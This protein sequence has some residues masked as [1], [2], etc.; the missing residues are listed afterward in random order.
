MVSH[1]L[2]YRWVRPPRFG[3]GRISL[4]RS[5]TASIPISHDPPWRSMLLRPPRKDTLC[6]I[7]LM[8]IRA[9]PERIHGVVRLF[10]TMVKEYC[11]HTS[12]TC[13][14]DKKNENVALK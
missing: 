10:I 13:E 14:S 2:T 1:N 9:H 7:F 12:K 5:D 6:M 8:I 4:A 11:A 3:S